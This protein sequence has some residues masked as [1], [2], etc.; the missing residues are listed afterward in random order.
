MAPLPQ[1]APAGAPSALVVEDLSHA[2]GA[3]KALDHVS[4]AVQPGAI[5]AVAGRGMPSLETG[6]RG[7]LLV[8]VEVRVPTRLTGE[9]RAEVLRLEAELGSEA[10]RDEDDGFFGR[11][12]SAFR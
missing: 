12:K 4:F 8:R 10:Y 9:Q 7:D 3:R 1:D 6:R 2:Y 11:L 5:H